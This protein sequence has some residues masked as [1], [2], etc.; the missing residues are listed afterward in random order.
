[1]NKLDYEYLEDK[2]N[3]CQDVSW[4]DV[5][6]KIDHEFKNRSYNFLIEKRQAPT[7]VLHN[8]YLPGTLK[9][10]FERVNEEMKT[11]VL[12][13]Y[14]SLGS[15]SPTFG[16]HMDPMDVLLIQAIGNV[17]YKLDNN[18]TESTTVNLSPGDGIIIKK[19]VYHTPI[20]KEPRVTLS[21]SWR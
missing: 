2:F 15:N 12:H 8:F 18:T 7:F 14:A 9:T 17:S 11:K 13:V 4:E 16:R 6:S 19:G 1:M 10:S 21:F 20:I 3:Y 5:I